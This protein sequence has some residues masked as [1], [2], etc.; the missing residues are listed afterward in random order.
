MCEP[1]TVFTTIT[2]KIIKQDQDDKI[3]E[4][5]IKELPLG[6]KEISC[7]FVSLQLNA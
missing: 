4:I 3:D 2:L 1:K 5:Q 6:N 7:L